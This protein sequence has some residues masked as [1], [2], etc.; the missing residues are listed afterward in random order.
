[1]EIY[2]RRMRLAARTIQVAAA[3]HGQAAGQTF[4]NG[5]EYPCMRDL[6]DV[7]EVALTLKYRFFL[8]CFL[9]IISWLRSRRCFISALLDWD[10]CQTPPIDLC[11]IAH[12]PCIPVLLI[13]PFYFEVW[14]FPIILEELG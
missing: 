14:H 10:L 2:E 3:R 4:A 1:M 7:A 11:I 8:L 12:C 13:D 5:F 6:Q 9:F